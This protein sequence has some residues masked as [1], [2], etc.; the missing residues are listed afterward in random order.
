MV[1]PDP[2]VQQMGDED[3]LASNGNVMKCRNCEMTITFRM[4]K[5]QTRRNIHPGHKWLDAHELDCRMH[6]S[7]D[8]LQSKPQSLQMLDGH[9]HQSAPA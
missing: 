1:F 9:G 3:N 8:T 7:T 2:L 4:D 5:H 6:H